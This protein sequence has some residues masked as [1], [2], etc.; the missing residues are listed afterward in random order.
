MLRVIGWLFAL[1]FIAVG[2]WGYFFLEAAGV[3]LQ[4]EPKSAGTCTKVNGGGVVGVE[5]LTI[6]QDTNIAYLAGYD[7]RAA[8][9]GGSPRGAIWVYDL[10]VPGSSPV[11][12]TQGQLLEGF[13]PHGINLFKGPDG[14][15][16][17]FV[18]NH[19]NKRHSVEIFDVDGAVLTHRRTVSGPELVSPNDL[20]SVGAESFYVTNDHGNV[21]GWMR[22]AEDFG[23]LQLS[24][25][26]FFNGQKFSAALE[27]LG[28]ANGINVG[29]DGRSL[30]VSAMSERAVRIYDRD[31]QTNVLT[32]RA[33]VAV[34]G[35][36]D[37]IELLNDGDLLVGVHSKILDFL[38]HVGDAAKLSP[39]HVLR[40]RSDG[41]GSFSPETVYYNLGDEISGGS[42]GASSQKRLLVGAIFEKKIL[43][44]VW[45]A[46]P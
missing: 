31:V 10:N 22:T 7:R 24:T 27:G 32:E 18:I 41:K 2:V 9:A 16:V 6:D 23:R 12:V 14:K 45:E 15:H 42:V 21:Q 28:G 8:L 30:Y 35:F 39:T 3:F 25:V 36:A 20:V 19:A 44:C 5:D 34:P 4:I 26:K 33:R 29:S 46:A 38:G 13:L 17:L 1:L 37:N 43:D 11:D 40:L